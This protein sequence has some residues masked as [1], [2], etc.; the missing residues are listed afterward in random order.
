[1]ESE[2]KSFLSR[3]D[4]SIIKSSIKDI[5]YGISLCDINLDDSDDVKFIKRTKE[6]LDLIA[7]VDPLRFSRVKKELRYIV[8]QELISGGT[9]RRG[10]RACIIDFGRYKFDENH[11]WYLYCYAGTIVHET[12][13]AYIYSRNIRYLPQNR[14]RIEKICHSEKNRFLKKI[15][16]ELADELIREFNETNWNLYWHGSKWQKLK[17]LLKRIRKSLKKNA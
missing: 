5:Y 17:A 2:H 9:Y 6:A 7:K 15:G 16:N 12:T 13:H 14:V 3:I 10:L 11:E 8:N 4:E 1:M